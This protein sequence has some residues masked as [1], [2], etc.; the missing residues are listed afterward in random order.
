MQKVIEWRAPNLQVCGRKWLRGGVVGLV[1]IIAFFALALPAGALKLDANNP[2]EFDRLFF[3]I[4]QELHSYNK[5]LYFYSNES[6]TDPIPT[7]YDDLGVADLYR[8]DLQFLHT[9]DRSQLAFDQQVNYDILEWGLTRLLEETDFIYHDYPASFI[10]PGPLFFPYSCY[11]NFDIS[12]KARAENYIQR[13]GEFPQIFQQLISALA[14]R[15]AM[16]MIPPAVVLER[17]QKQVVDFTESQVS[18]NQLY[19]YFYLKVM[20][21]NL[22]S[23][24]KKELCK[25]AEA[26]IGDKPLEAYRNLAAYLEKLATKA[27]SAPGIWYYPDGDAYYAQ[28]LRQHT[29][30]D[31]TPE[32]VHNLGLKEVAR[33]RGEM[34]K[35]LNE[36]GYTGVPFA[37]ALEKLEAK[38][39]LTD[40]DQI[41]D[42]YRKI[43]REAEARLP[44][45]FENVPQIQVDVEATYDGGLSA[46]YTDNTFYVDLSYTQ[47]QHTMQTIAYHETVPGHHFQS[48]FARSTANPFLR[49]FSQ[50]TAYTEGWALYAETL[51]Y[52]HGMF[53]DKESLLGYWQHQLFRAVRLVVDTGIHYKRWSREE[54]IEY[55][56]QNTGMQSQAEAEVDRYIVW[57]GQ[58]TAYMIGELKILELRA[59]AMTAL[60]DKFDLKEFH[61]EI[62]KYGELP[63]KTLEKVVDYYIAWKK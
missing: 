14:R 35:L 22:S 28:L 40:E 48:S 36:L 8:E 37:D 47:V 6:A 51:A 44:E 13:L 55:F 4:Y 9:Y 1:L 30:T 10:F 43:I 2:I 25:K 11:W 29:T 53:E 31:L 16:G 52:E 38:N 18:A 12:T 23:A 20:Q 61:R 57:P 7:F 3:F 63:L 58:A 33:I 41:L 62:L 15:E 24:E 21:M 56:G 45:F 46:Y 19:H 54:A 27:G 17:L 34:Q 32:E 5:Y 60:G 50:N 49:E 59:K 26:A 39:K 42:G